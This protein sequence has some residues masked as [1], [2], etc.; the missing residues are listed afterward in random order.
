M[1]ILPCISQQIALSKNPP[2]TSHSFEQLPLDGVEAAS[3]AQASV[4]PKPS[5]RAGSC[6]DPVIAIKAGLFKICAL[7][8]EIAPCI[9]L[10]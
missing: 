3:A 7:F 4:T 5:R 9:M 2:P 8:C 10:L 6:E 1:Y